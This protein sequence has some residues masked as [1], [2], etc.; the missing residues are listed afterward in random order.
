MKIKI[1]SY[2]D[3]G[4]EVI[5]RNYIDP[6]K[7]NLQEFIDD[8]QTYINEAE[9]KSIDGLSGREEVEAL[10]VCEAEDSMSM[11]ELMDDDGSDEE[12]LPDGTEEYQ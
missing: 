3:Y 6:T 4:K 1:T 10:K 5:T 12:D 9:Q 2:D 11:E 8:S 7:D